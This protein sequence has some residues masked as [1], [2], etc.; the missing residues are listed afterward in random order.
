MSEGQITLTV[1]HDLALLYLGL[2]H[3][4]DDELD[5][6]ETT[7]IE[8]KL[9]QWQ[10]HKD[11]ALIHHVL[12][13]ATLSYMNEHGEKR[14]KEAVDVLGRQLPERLR[15]AILRDLEDI[16]QADRQVTEGEEHF[17]NRVADLQGLERN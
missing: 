12:R 2:A 1:L 4:A 17:I 9:R 8:A 11:P 13:E 7:E 6:S 16:A 10:P 5:P 15:I 3:G 14:L